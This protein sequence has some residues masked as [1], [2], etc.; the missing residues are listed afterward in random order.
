MSAEILAILPGSAR[1][2]QEAAAAVAA[3]VGAAAAEAA[4]VTVT[5]VAG[6]TA[7]AALPHAAGA[8]PTRLLAPGA[9]PPMKL[10]VIAAAPH[11][12]RASAGAGLEVYWCRPS[13][14]KI[15]L[16]PLQPANLQPRSCDTAARAEYI[17]KCTTQGIINVTLHLVFTC[18]AEI[19]VAHVLHRS[20]STCPGPRS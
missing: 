16:L 15:A 5:A 20:F 9:A 19:S 11:M 4:T 1:C 3:A 12:S 10:L 17:A 2:A 6:V 7:T 14:V 18:L 13:G 8:P